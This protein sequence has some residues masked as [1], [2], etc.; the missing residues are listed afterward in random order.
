MRIG[1]CLVAAVVFGLTGCT[2]SQEG[3]TATGIPITVLGDPSGTAALKK[4][5]CTVRQDVRPEADDIVLVA[6]SCRQGVEAK[7]LD[8]LDKAAGA[9]ARHLAILLTEV[10]A[11]ADAGLDK[12]LIELVEL[13]SKWILSGVVGDDAATD[14]L[15]VLRTDDP[16]LGEK[17]KALAARK[18]EPIRLGK[19]NRK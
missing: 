16:E 5:G 13:E 2:S 11:V 14:K 8:A 17:I 6:V 7:T 15:L 9:T 1:A 12:D 4:A 18:A 19:P 3:G 10:D